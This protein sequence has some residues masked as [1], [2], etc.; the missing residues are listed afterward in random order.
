MY[1]VRVIENTDLSI[2]LL[3]VTRLF[4]TFQNDASRNE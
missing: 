2:Y 1:E 4:L 3:N